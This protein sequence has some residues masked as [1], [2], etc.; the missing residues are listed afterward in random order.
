MSPKIQQSHL[1]PRSLID[2]SPRCWTQGAKAE[3]S[4]GGTGR[5]ASEARAEQERC[6]AGTGAGAELERREVA[7]GAERGHQ[8]C[9]AEHVLKV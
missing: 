2:P 6:G 1:I 9:K 8:R 5:I 4:G 7:T 3:R